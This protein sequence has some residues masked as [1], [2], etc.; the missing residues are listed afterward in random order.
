MQKGELSNHSI[1]T[2]LCS[3]EK[4][5]HLSA[6]Q[7][8]SLSVSTS[9]NSN[10]IS[11]SR[12]HTSARPPAHTLSLSLSHFVL[13]FL[14]FSPFLSPT[15]SLTH[16]HTHSSSLFFSCRP[17]VFSLSLPRFTSFCS[18]VFLSLSCCLSLSSPLLNFL[19]SPLFLCSSRLLLHSCGARAQ[20]QSFFVLC[21]C[22]WRWE[23][24]GKELPLG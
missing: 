1:T 23:M 15:Q 9:T 5:V 14:T 19:L 16:T 10:A 12:F 8:A 24:F 22:A 17:L 2:R 7:P 4:R 3:S 20:T 6:C 11:A 21:C 18:F 13:L